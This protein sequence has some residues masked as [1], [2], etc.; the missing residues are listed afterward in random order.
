VTPVWLWQTFGARAGGRGVCDDHQAARHAAED[1]LRSGDATTALIE[2]ATIELGVR[3]LT[4]GYRRIGPRW[5]ARA[6]DRVRW[7]SLKTA[8]PAEELGGER[9]G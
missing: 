6:G 1:R 9:H 2:E 5:H 7:V 4:D 3:T 8:S